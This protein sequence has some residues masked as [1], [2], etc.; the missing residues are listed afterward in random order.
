MEYRGVSSPLTRAGTSGGQAVCWQLEPEKPGSP[1]KVA[2]RTGR[3][4]WLTKSH[5]CRQNDRYSQ[6][7]ERSPEIGSQPSCTPKRIMRSRASQKSGVAKPTKTKT[8]ARSEERRV[9]KE[10]RSRW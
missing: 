10:C 5:C 4:R 2:T 6:L 1:P 3:S 7:S 9:G 8:V